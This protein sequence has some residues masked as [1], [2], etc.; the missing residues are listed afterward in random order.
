[1]RA[2]EQDKKI[3]QLQNEL[4]TAA[5]EFKSLRRKCA[6]CDATL[7]QTLEEVWVNPKHHLEQDRNQRAARPSKS[8]LATNNGLQNGIR[9][10]CPRATGS[11]FGS[12]RNY[13]KH[14]DIF[15]G[16]RGYCHRLKMTNFEW[17]QLLVANC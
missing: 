11:V 10:Q 2:T 4:A 17:K 15:R 16:T 12:A 3:K 13:R 14:E 1:M 7:K 9:K 5:D 8:R 6:I